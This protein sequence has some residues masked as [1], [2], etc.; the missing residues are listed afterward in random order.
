MIKLKNE[1]PHLYTYEHPFTE[2]LWSCTWSNTFDQVRFSRNKYNS[3]TLLHTGLHQLSQT[4]SK[5]L[6]WRKNLK[7]KKHCKLH[8]AAQRTALIVTN[9]IEIVELGK[10]HSKLPLLILLS[11]IVHDLCTIRILFLSYQTLCQEYF[12]YLET[13]L[14]IV[15]KSLNS[16]RYLIV[17]HYA[18]VQQ[19]RLREHGG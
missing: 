16:V 5:V 14:Q 17:D 1:L 11:F 3:G 19:N 7:K 18:G 9:N 10:K 8:F 2:I 12:L 6:N 15:S 4:I 13:K